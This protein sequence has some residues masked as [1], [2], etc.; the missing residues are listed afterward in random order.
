MQN[1]PIKYII[2]LLN[3]LRPHPMIIYPP[4]YW[5]S[6][7][8]AALGLIG[9]AYLS[10][11]FLSDFNPW[12]IAPVGASAVL[13]FAV[14]ASPLAQP[15]S[16]IGGNL[17][18]AVVGIACAKLIAAPI[19]AVALAV[20]LAIALMMRLRCLHPPSGAVAL[21][22]ILGGPQVSEL[23]YQFVWSPVLI[24]SL[25][26]VILAI[27][28]NLLAKRDYPHHLK[29]PQKSTKDLGEITLE[30]VEKALRQHHELLDIDETDLLNIVKETEQIAKDR[31]KRQ[32]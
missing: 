20:S 22:A 11:L 10:H 5:L 29:T 27:I 28:F 23:G 16:V 15:W 2:S 4:D 24:N 18:A 21:T 31:R 12:F 26:L 1:T 3:K 7:L 14:P 9:T 32:P 6:P 8:G 13:L 30:D 17:I 19:L 25:L